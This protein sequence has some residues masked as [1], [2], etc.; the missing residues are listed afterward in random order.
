MFLVRLCQFFSQFSESIS[1]FSSCQP[2]LVSIKFWG[3][4]YDLFETSATL[5]SSPKSRIWCR[6]WG[7]FQLCIQTF[8]H[9]RPIYELSFFLGKA[10]VMQREIFLMLKVFSCAGFGEKAR[11]RELRSTIRGGGLA[12]AGGSQLGSPLR[13]LTPRE[14]RY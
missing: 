2:S 12:G 1:Q 3:E 7:A 11:Q 4:M 13:Y 8:N 6:F 9:Q 5:L 14:S 10:P